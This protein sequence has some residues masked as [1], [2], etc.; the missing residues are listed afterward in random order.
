MPVAVPTA[1]TV[2]VKMPVVMLVVGP[3]VVTLG[4]NR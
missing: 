4:T 2:V 3:V 1:V